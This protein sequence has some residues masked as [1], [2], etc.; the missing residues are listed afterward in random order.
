MVRFTNA[1]GRKNSIPLLLTFFR[2]EKLKGCGR[3]S[4]FFRETF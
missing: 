4:I 1:E 3:K 2:Q